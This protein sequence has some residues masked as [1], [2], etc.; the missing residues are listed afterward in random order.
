MS[1]ILLE[2]SELFANCIPD[3]NRARVVA[4]GCLPSIISLLDDDS[5]LAFVIPVLFNISVDY[6]KSQSYTKIRPL[7]TN[8]ILDPAI[9]AIYQAGINPALIGLLSGARLDDAPVL[10]NYACKLLSQVATQGRE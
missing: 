1:E 10:V 5:V 8:F 2:D 9:K 3:E 4:S 6:G 7:L